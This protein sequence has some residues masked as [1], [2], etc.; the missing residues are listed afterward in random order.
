MSTRRPCWGPSPSI[1][2]T[3]TLDARFPGQWFQSE[4]GLHYNWH[5]QYDPTT[6]R[7]TQP[8]PLG[9]V[10]GPSVYGYVK[11]LPQQLADFRGLAGDVIPFPRKP[12]WWSP[13]IP[14]VRDIYNAC[15]RWFEKDPCPVE[16]AEINRRLKEFIDKVTESLLDQKYMM[17]PQ[18]LIELRNL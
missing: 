11:G 10:D 16:Q 8:D 1:T 6:G 12:K 18:Y 2:G 4:T 5:R 9:F 13:I 17:W 14:M 7:Y 3:A 15:K